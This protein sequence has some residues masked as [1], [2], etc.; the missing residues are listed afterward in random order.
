MSLRNENPVVFGDTGGGWVYSVRQHQL[1]A[2]FIGLV[3]IIT[4]V[5]TLLP[6]GDASAATTGPPSVL[7]PPTAYFG[8][9]IEPRGTE[10][11]NDA[12]L[13]VESEIG[14][15]LAID[16][17]Y[18]QWNSTFPNS[19]QTWTV[20]QGRIPFINWKAGGPWA[21]IANGSQDA[22]IIAH[23]DAIKAFGY[24]MYLTFHHEPEDDLATYGTPQD[25]AAAFRHIVTCSALAASPT[26]RSCG[27]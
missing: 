17:Y 20:G 12:V 10:S 26:W 25:F 22:T 5:A 18:Y 16:H 3:A 19:A 27:R 23:A 14:R 15:K 1:T 11:Q 24:P 9:R 4:L 21:A 13:R 6:K 7:T 8:S 2:S